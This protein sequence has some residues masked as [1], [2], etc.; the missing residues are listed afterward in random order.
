MPIG[1]NRLELHNAKSVILGAIRARDCDT[2]RRLLQSNPT[3]SVIADNRGQTLL[4]TA[5]IIGHPD[6]IRIFLR[7]NAR[8]NA[9]DY[10]GN[11][12]LH[13]STSLA[14]TVSLIQKANIE[15]KNLKGLT[16]L[17]SAAKNGHLESVRSLLTANANIDAKDN[18]QSTPLHYAS[19]QGHVEIATILLARGAK[20][21]SRNKSGMTPLLFT[22]SKW[23][24]ESAMVS[25]LLNHNVDVQV[26]DK[27]GNSALYYAV[28]RKHL[29]IFRMLLNAG[30]AGYDTVSNTA[31]CELWNLVQRPG[32]E[33][34]RKILIE[35]LKEESKP[36]STQVILTWHRTEIGM[37]VVLRTQLSDQK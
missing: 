4:H 23:A 1:G 22:V 16:A 31:S 19:R 36:E 11:T 7:T 29:G 28:M 9:Q 18:E 8:V 34:F 37:R 35:K 10:A 27:K 12:P 17:H 13:L 21:N 5:A 25:F 6:I 14:T 33:R 32:R 24:N 30:A 2:V 26:K 3:L 15:M 20:I